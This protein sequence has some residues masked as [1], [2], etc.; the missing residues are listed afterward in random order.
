MILI[1]GRNERG[2]AEFGYGRDGRWKQFQLRTE[3]AF[4]PRPGS[5]KKE[6]NTNFGRGHLKY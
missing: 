5:V 1:L 6:Q 2:S 4:M 3:A